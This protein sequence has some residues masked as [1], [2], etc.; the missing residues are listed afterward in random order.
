MASHDPHS[1]ADLEQAAIRHVTFDL[2]MD[3][4][5]RQLAGTALYELDRPVQG[6][7][8]LDT[9]DLTIVS[10][11]ASGRPL[12]PELGSP[13]PIRGQRLR[14]KGLHGASSFKLQFVTSP[15]AN[16][17][18]WLT[19]AQTAGGRQPFLFTQCQPHHA[20]SIFPCQD[21]PSVR[22][23]YDATLD[24]PSPLAAVMA[25]APIGREESG[26][27]RRFTFRM[28][29]SIPSYLLAFAAGEIDS[30]DLSPRIRVYAEPETLDA[31]AWELAETEAMLAEAEKLYG[32]YPWERYDMLVLPPSFPYGGME[33]P[34]LTFLTPTVVVGDRSLTNVIAHELA[35]SWT[36]NLVTN[37]T[38]EDFWL[39]E[40]WTTYA[41][42]R[43]LEALEGEESAML[44]A[45]SGRLLMARAMD[46]FG[47][48]A[49]A[50]RLQFSQAGIDPE[51]VISHVAYEKGYSFL[52]R[53][54]R[55]VGRQAF[56]AFTHRYIADHRF[57]SITTEA[58]VAFLR[59]ELPQAARRVDL[60]SWLYEPGLPADAPDF[61]TP[62]MDAV[63]SVL[64]DLQEGHPPTKDGVA[65]WNTTQIYL[66][67]QY[68]PRHLSLKECRA[69]EDALS[70]KT[71]PIDLFLSQWLEIAILSE[72]RDVLPVAEDLV[73]RVGRM[74]IILPVF[75]AIV[76]AEWSRP[77]ARPLFE[78]VR[79][80]HH[81]ITVRA[82]ENLLA[83]QGL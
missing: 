47:W 59:R 9:R 42:R 5:Q 32:A 73:G 13:D 37:A 35:H 2:R 63:S 58:F 33:N 65:Q 27:R 55:A 20:R 15:G 19:P 29:Q 18:Q 82:M 70:L 7:L 79:S 76:Q 71:T 30:R 36:G 43:I 24:V 22:F 6:T 28:P 68:L 40:G 77:R 67:L 61:P 4:G 39:N 78:R 80:G 54:E 31:A 23:T 69:L 53:L 66:F 52:V 3:F 46:R 8:D 44:R 14:L 81:P 64:F 17:L 26:G 25:A 74:L 12:S 10:A 41:E 56:D 34:R 51:D 21:S 45:I 72:Y 57:Q 83:L 38:W 60:K 62:L 48:D 75:R 1:Y 50:T 16:A 11:E 49:D